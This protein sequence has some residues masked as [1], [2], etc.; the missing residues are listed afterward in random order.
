[1][2]VHVT[3]KS[4]PGRIFMGNLAAIDTVLDETTRSL[5]IRV[6]V[7]NQDGALKPNMY[8]NALIESS[9]G[10]KLSVPEEAVMD[11][12][13]KQIVFVDKGNGVFASR[14]VV[15]GQRSEGYI[16]ILKGLKAGD[17]VVTSG[18]FLIDSESKLKS[19]G[20]GHAH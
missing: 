8:V 4:L 17:Q 12:G 2:L 6:A 9:L 19:T 3:A 15:I 1:M 5:K 11:T 13:D 18:N 16:E 10:A 7:K 20:G 14:P